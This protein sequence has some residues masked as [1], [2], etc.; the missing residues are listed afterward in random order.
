MVLIGERLKNLRK[1][2]NYSE[3]EVARYLGIS[4]SALSSYERDVRKPSYENLVKLSSLYNVTLD[5]L[6]CG[7]KTIK[8]D[9]LSEE[10]FCVVQ[11]LITLFK[12]EKL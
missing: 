7:M 12:K 8:V 3:T 1:K 6:L 9:D 11:R 10:E 2:N 5:Y 4:V